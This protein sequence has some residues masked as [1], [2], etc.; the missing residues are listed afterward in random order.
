MGGHTCSQSWVFEP[1]MQWED[2]WVHP[3]STHLGSSGLWLTLSMDGSVLNISHILI[4]ERKIPL[5]LNQD[6]TGIC[7][8]YFL[9]IK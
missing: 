5:T 4:S 1:A 7:Y 3:C 2:L 6:A 9:V 8:I